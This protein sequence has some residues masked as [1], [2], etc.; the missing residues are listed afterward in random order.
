MTIK[1][2]TEYFDEAT[3]NLRDIV[4]E[5]KD[6]LADV[7]FDTF[8]GTGFS[9]GVVIPALALEMGKNY[10]LIRKEGDDSHHGGGRMVGSLG[11][12][13]IFLDDFVSLGGTRRRVVD[14]VAAA[15]VMND[16]STTYVGQYL[17]GRYVEQ[18]FIPFDGD[19]D[20]IKNY[21]AP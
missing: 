18:K 5:A 16:H 21:G 7:D 3:Q 2:R 14:K 1:F 15:C 8:V 17:Y 11:H 19:W 10:A 20:F 9:G 12:R 13:W 4:D 6:L